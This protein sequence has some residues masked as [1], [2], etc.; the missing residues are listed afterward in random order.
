[1]KICLVL[2]GSYPY[3]RG[4]VSTWVDSYIRALPGHEFILWTINDIEDKR[5]KFGYDIP[6]NVTQ[7]YENFLSSAL[8]IRVKKNPELK[9]SLKEREAFTELIKRRNPDWKV[10]LNSFS[11]QLNRPV[12]FFL[13]SEFLE[14]LKEL[15][16]EEFQYAGFKDLFW[17][18]RSM[19]LPLL[20]LMGQE[21]PEAD[22]YHSLS[23]GYAGVLASI[24]SIKINKP[25]VLTEHGIYTRERE[26]ELL[27]S[28]W[29]IPYFKELW[30]STFI[31]FSR[32]AYQQAHQVTSLY[33]NA[34]LTQQELGCPP[35][36]CNVIGN[37]LDF[38]ELEQIPRKMDNTWVD[39]GAIIRF[40]QIK[41]IKTLIYTFFRLKQEL[42]NVRLHI[43]GGIDDEE[44]YQECID[45]I[46]YLHV[47]DIIVAGRVD[48]IQYLEKLDFTVLTSLSE[49]QPF[50][51]L[52][53]FAARRPVV[54]TDVGSCRELIEGREDDDF[55]MAG[56]C[57]PPMHQSPL[58]QALRDMC[59]DDERRSKMGDVGNL[60]VK[61]Y[62]NR[63]TMVRNYL[64]VYEKAIVKWQ[65]LDSN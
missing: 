40:A 50:A 5:G 28:D 38:H 13:S 2:E 65:E 56:I 49:G 35:G 59:L 10:L 57:V 3:V 7:I 33:Q 63:D 12:E 30:I 53:S 36:K 19:F 34:S 15:S 37:G 55:G 54:S 9:L 4:G 24:A 17:T 23:T 44:Y 42:P 60:R 62:Y 52:E 6:P 22:I 1:M 21:I 27:R 39:I 61:K 8:D 31:M 47:D 11:S 26:E 58:L 14:M 32:F 64:Q 16:R 25:F 43:L 46:D 29:I 51:I 48:I 41:D 45:L 20:Y 18:I